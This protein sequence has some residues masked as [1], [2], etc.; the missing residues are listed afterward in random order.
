MQ[1]LCYWLQ[2]HA[3]SSNSRAWFAPFRTQGCF[4][5]PGTGDGCTGA[6][7]TLTTVDLQGAN[8]KL[9]FFLHQ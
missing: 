7:R 8:G 4:Y 2:I 3:K 6:Q 1:R 5:R 9:N